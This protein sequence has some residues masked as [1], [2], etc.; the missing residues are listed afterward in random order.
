MQ[1]RSGGIVIEDA[2]TDIPMTTTGNGARNNK[3]L[4]TKCLGGL[5]RQKT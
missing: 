2:M 1:T 3:G 4:K 5:G